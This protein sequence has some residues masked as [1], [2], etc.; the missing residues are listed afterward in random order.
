MAPRPGAPSVIREMTYARIFAMGA[1]VAL[2]A[3]SSAGAAPWSKPQRLVR[4]SNTDPVTLR[5]AMDGSGRAAFVW[6]HGKLIETRMRGVDGRLGHIVVLRRMPHGNMGLPQ[7]AIGSR[8]Q[9][10]VLWLEKASGKS[11]GYVYAAIRSGG[12]FGRP[13]R[14]GISKTWPQGGTGA[15]AQG[16]SPK[17]AIAPN[18][19]VGAL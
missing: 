12:R 11:R 9:V 19:T 18:G 5:I 8:G 1:A 2:V 3:A 15:G 17:V 14:V 10:A 16:D 6:V 7:I 4:E 13:V